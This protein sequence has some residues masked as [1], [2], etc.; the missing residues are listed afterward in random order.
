M[1]IVPV[2]LLFVPYWLWRYQYYGF[3]FPNAFY[4]KSIAL[5]Y[6]S[7]GWEYARLYFTTYYVFALLPILALAG[8]W[9]AWKA[10]GRIRMG[11]L[12]GGIQRSAAGGHPLFLAFL[13]IA[14]Y[15]L[16]II[17]IGGD[18]MFAR[19]FIPITPLM[20]F[21]ME[22]L[23]GRLMKA[24]SSSIVAALV[25]VATFFRSDHY[26][27]G[28]FVNE[29][30]DEARHYTAQDLQTARND[31][32]MLHHYF[33]GLPVRIAFDAGLLK[34]VYYVD[35]PFAMEASAGLTDT[36]IAHQSLLAR[37]RPG[38]EKHA[39][40]DYLIHRG[41]NFYL[42]HFGSVPGGE[43]V[44]NAI[45]FGHLVERIIICDDTIMSK[46]AEHPEI[47]FVHLRAYL[48]NY[49]VRMP[50]YSRERVRQDYDFLKSFYFDHNAD[51]ARENVFLSY[52][53]AAP[54]Q[55]EGKRDGS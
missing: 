1:V 5:P 42:G 27:H 30:A 55:P 18:F 13:F 36:T 32:A 47:Q 7:Q 10:G 46:L 31:G 25:L 53:R 39:S 41:I 15:A 22:V 43:P 6:Y 51:S 16:F 35:P 37:G 2:V 34:L 19:F 49:I 50:S 12:R 14:G 9:Q 11:L 3:F 21:A 20:F 4:A 29:V 45:T 8:L 26:V 28:L 52:L 54:L 24:P 48:D 44:L 40:V 33:R 38:H 23:I 17:R